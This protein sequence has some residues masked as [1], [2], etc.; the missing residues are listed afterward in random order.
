[1]PPNFDFEPISTTL[2]NS[3]QEAKLY[4][5]G[6]G[7]GDPELLTIKALRIISSADV[8]IADNLISTSILELCGGQVII[9]STKHGKKGAAD[10][11]QDEIMK[12]TLQ[13]L[14]TRLPIPNPVNSFINSNSTSNSNSLLSSLVNFNSN[15]V[16]LENTSKP[17]IVVRLKNGDPFVFGRAGEEIEYFSKNQFSIEVISG[18]SSCLLAPLV[19]NIP[20]TLR[21]VAD[22]FLVTTAQGKGGSIPELPPYSSTRTT[23]FLMPVARLE[24]LVSEL[25]KIGYPEDCPSALVQRASFEDQKVV[26]TILKDIPE[27]SKSENIKSPSI[28]IIGWTVNAL[29]FKKDVN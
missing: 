23:I 5:V 24:N 18:I 20:V 3:N 19:G 22:Q 8:V 13:A 26:K 6:A 15:N 28:L 9:A 1:M 2:G 29:E 4:L 7:P 11:S 17:F 14:Q 10:E 27:V 21:G 12:L 16:P 25:T